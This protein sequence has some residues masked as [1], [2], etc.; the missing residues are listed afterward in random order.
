M[1][2]THWLDATLRR[3]FAPLHLEIIDDSARHIGH[4]GAA[5]G[6]GHFRIVLVSD[7]FRGMDLVARQR[8]VYE[9]LGDAMRSRIHALALRTVT[10]EEWN[11][12]PPPAIPPHAR[13]DDRQT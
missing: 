2:T 9:A 1:D 6:G 12:K 7:V 13:N 10:P 3:A 5:S 8:L 4:A 11:T